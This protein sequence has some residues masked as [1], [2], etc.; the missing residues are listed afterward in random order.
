MSMHTILVLV[1]LFHMTYEYK[2]LLDYCLRNGLHICTYY[3]V[4][5]QGVHN[6][7]LKSDEPSDSKN[8]NGNLT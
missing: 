8:Y 6:P 2:S 5:A 1:A 3:I 4:N 7:A